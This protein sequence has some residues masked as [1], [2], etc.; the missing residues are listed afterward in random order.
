M[1]YRVRQERAW[2]TAGKPLNYPCYGAPS[3][4]AVERETN[5]GNWIVVRRVGSREYAEYLAEAMEF[6]DRAREVA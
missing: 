3:Q 1:I 6:A 4:W 5:D 2:T